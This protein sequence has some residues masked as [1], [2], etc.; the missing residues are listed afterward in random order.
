MRLINDKVLESRRKAIDL[1]KKISK[2]A[3]KRSRDVLNEPIEVKIK[4]SNA[5]SYIGIG[6]IAIGITLHLVK[7]Y[8][9]GESIFILGVLTLG[10]NLLTLSLLSKKCE[11]Q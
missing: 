7:F 6:L 1:S 3:S 5:G 11:K 4:K 2:N 9:L 8:S 10:S